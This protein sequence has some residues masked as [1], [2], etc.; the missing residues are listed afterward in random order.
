MAVVR[1]GTIAA[2]LIALLC[3]IFVSPV[4]AAAPYDALDSTMVS[5][6]GTPGDYVTGGAQWEFDPSNSHTTGYASTTRIQFMMTGGAQNTTVQVDLAPQEG[7]TFAVGHYPWA[8]RTDYTDAG[9]PGIDIE[10]SG[11]GCDPSWGSFEVRDIATRGTYVVRLDVLFIQYCDSGSDLRGEV[12]IGEP[13]P[14]GVYVSARGLSWPDSAP[15]AGAGGDPV[16]LRNPGS[17]AVALGP[18]LVSGSHPGDFVVQ[19][20]S[21]ADSLPAGGVC[22]LRVRFTPSAPGPRSA[23]L[24]VSIG[25]V[26]YAIQL[27]GVERPGTTSLTLHSEPGDPE[28]HGSGGD[29]SFTAADSDFSLVAA[30]AHHVELQVGGPGAP[31]ALRFA[32]GTSRQAFVPGSYPVTQAYSVLTAEGS[33]LVGAVSCWMVTGSFDVQSVAFS[34]ADGRLERLVATFVQHCNGAA[35]AL[36]G[37]LRYQDGSFP[38]ETPSVTGLG[39][40]LAGSSVHLTWTNPVTDSYAY[41]VIR[42]QRAPTASLAAFTGD[43]VYAGLGTSVDLQRP[44]PGYATV[45]SA[46]AVSTDG[47]VSPPT[48]VSLTR[49][50]P[51]LTPITPL[52]VLDTRAGSGLTQGLPSPIPGGTAETVQV[53][54]TGGIPDDATAVAITLTAVTPAGPGF[55]VVYPQGPRPIVSNINYQPG[56]TKATYAIVG[57]TALGT[58]DMYTNG[59]AVDVLIDVTGYVLPGSQYA[60]VLPTRVLDSRN[61]SGLSQGL[62]HPLAAGAGYPVTIS[63]LAGVATDATSVAVNITI[64]SG[65]VPGFLVIFPHGQ[66]RPL[67]SNINFGR[68]VTTAAFALSRLP[69]DG[70]LTI[71]SSAPGVNAILDVSG[72]TTAES[73]YTPTTPTRVLDTRTGSGLGR[74]LPHPLSPGHEYTVRLTGLAGVPSNATAVAITVTVVTPSASGYLEIYPGHV[75]RPLASNINYRRGETQANFVVTGLP[76]DGTLTIWSAVAATDVLIDVAGYL[77]PA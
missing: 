48:T 72:Y 8:Q 7:D 21:C 55:L 71:Y 53:T 46:F 11:R 42:Q 73:P 33:M 76:P 51:A 29:F 15:W 12:Q 77:T 56:V 5:V 69:A 4:S 63:G 60:P 22:V 45:F 9:H 27:D 74:G 36:T 17:T 13:R 10:G 49:P 39:A 35:A 32:A 52:R 40:S 47:I 28:T 44:A 23:M 50:G 20:S 3:A 54:G 19:D 30:D 57:L 6:F 24:S 38:T 2:V 68:G 65:S 34:P 64:V 66:A 59:A 75:P 14:A 43:A 41:T 61:G 67:A 62:P 1:G 16:Y 58:L 70:K 18:Q 31:W 26:A 37:E 25:G